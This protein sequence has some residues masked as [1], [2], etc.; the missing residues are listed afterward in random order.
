MKVTIDLAKLLEFHD[1]HAYDYAMYSP[2][3]FRA[4]MMDFLVQPDDEI[5]RVDDHTNDAERRLVSSDI[6]FN[7]HDEA[8]L[9]LKKNERAY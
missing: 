7:S 4:F 3:G 8:E 2:N 9:V 1:E 6:L 5:K